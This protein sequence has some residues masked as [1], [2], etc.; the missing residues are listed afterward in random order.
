MNKSEWEEILFE[1]D[2]CLLVKRQLPEH[3]ELLSTLRALIP[4]TGNLN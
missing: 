4:T 1:Q 3:D 2:H